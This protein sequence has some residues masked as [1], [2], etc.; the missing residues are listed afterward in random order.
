LKKEAKSNPK[1][2]RLADVVTEIRSFYS[3]KEINDVLEESIEQY[4]SVAEEYSQWLGSFL[5]DSEAMQENKE[6]VKQ[7]T[8]LNKTKPKGKPNTVGKKKGKPKK[9]QSSTD[10]VQFKELMLSASELGEAE[11]LFEAIE[12]I[13]RKIEQLKIM[14][15]SIVELEKSRLGKDITYITFIRDGVPEKIVLRHRKDQ[16]FGKKFQYLADFSVLQET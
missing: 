12:D 2:L 3:I 13:N 16:E 15:E 9:T 6:W 11:I 5:R 7:M 10:W 8:A 1:V 14:K 4:K